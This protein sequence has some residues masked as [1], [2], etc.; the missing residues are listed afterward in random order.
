MLALF[1]KFA[2]W[3]AALAVVV[4]SLMPVTTPLPST[5]WDKSNHALAYV[6]LT[7]L[8]RHAYPGDKF[9]LVLGLFLHGCLAETLQSFT[10]YRFAEWSDLGAD[11][12]GIVLGY[13]MAY[14]YTLC[15]KPGTRVQWDAVQ[16]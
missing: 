16:K 11:V 15:Q 1:I 7:L 5:G 9:K 3:A 8:G 6:V 4:L 10:T 14:L 12:L 13:G 2:F